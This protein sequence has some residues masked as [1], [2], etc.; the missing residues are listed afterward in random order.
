MAESMEP[1]QTPSPLPNYRPAWVPEGYRKT[2]ER[3]GFQTRTANYRKEDQELS[4]TVSLTE[5]TQLSAAFGLDMTAEGISALEVNGTEAV[6]I[7]GEDGN[8]RLCWL[9]T[10]AGVSFELIAPEGLAA[11]Q[12]VAKQ[13]VQVD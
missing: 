11:L 6:F 12:R 5:E 7:P 1:G 3:G 13:V 10:E 8:N 9:D 4:F 2:G